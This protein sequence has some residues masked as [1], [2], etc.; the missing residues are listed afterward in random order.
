M[1]VAAVLA[2][3][4]AQPW[5]LT[6]HLSTKTAMREP[7]RLDQMCPDSQVRVDSFRAGQP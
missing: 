3:L 1:A 4:R 2:S 6:R 7:S 5:T